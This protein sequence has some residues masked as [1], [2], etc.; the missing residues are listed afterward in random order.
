[1]ALGLLPT[2]SNRQMHACDNHVARRTNSKPAPAKP[3][4]LRPAPD[5]TLLERLGLPALTSTEL[6]RIA[7]F[8]FAVMV[9]GAW[10]IDPAGPTSYWLCKYTSWCW[11]LSWSTM[12]LYL[13][14][15]LLVVAVIVSQAQIV[16]EW[17]EWDATYRAH[18]YD[19]RVSMPDVSA[20]KRDEIARCRTERTHGQEPSCMPLIL[21]WCSSFLRWSTGMWM[22]FALVVWALRPGYLPA[23]VVGAWPWQGPQLLVGAAAGGSAPVC[24]E[25]GRFDV[26]NHLVGV[27]SVPALWQAALVSVRELSLS[28]AATDIKLPPDAQQALKCMPGDA[29]QDIERL[30]VCSSERQPP[31][32]AP[33]GPPPLPPLVAGEPHAAVR[34]SWDTVHDVQRIDWGGY[35][36]RAAR[37]NLLAARVWRHSGLEGMQRAFN[38]L[39]AL[40]TPGVNVTRAAAALKELRRL[41]LPVAAPAATGGRGS[42]SGAGPGKRQGTERRKAEE[43]DQD[44]GRGALEQVGWARGKSRC[45]LRPVSVL[46]LEGTSPSWPC[47]THCHARCHRRW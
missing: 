35:L 28:S 42:G 20:G 33:L 34:L 31:V 39:G 7:G 11:N 38:A 4:R 45:P 23:Q 16:K 17:S 22:G 43:P 25:P 6:L 40:Q 29:G 27:P 37:V 18:K 5:E 9:G 19:L 44:K 15:P 8:A 21:A 41:Q 46:G 13:G 30:G 14:V 32:A 10:L 36:A 2:A 12:A 1:M 26:V 3:P 47:P 24:Y